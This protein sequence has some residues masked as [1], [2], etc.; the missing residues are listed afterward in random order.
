MVVAALSR[1][2][3][4]NK[5]ITTEHKRTLQ[6]KAG[7]IQKKLRVYNPYIVLLSETYWTDQ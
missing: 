2:T 6:V 1:A 5:N 4:K 7:R 3:I